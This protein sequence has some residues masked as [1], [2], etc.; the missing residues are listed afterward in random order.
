MIN[1]IN[2]IGIAVTNINKSRL[3]YEALLGIR[4][5]EEEEVQDQGVK[6]LKGIFPGTDCIYFELLQPLN[7]KSNLNKFLDKRG[8]G[9]HHICL[10][11]NNLETEMTNL[12][13]KG[14]KFINKKP[15]EGSEGEKIAFLHPKSTEGLL[16]ELHESDNKKKK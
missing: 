10:D 16:I 1:G 11:S 6:I 4:F 12:Q 3:I 7:E 14:F 8:Q 9:F 15:S 13:K 2:H 5:L